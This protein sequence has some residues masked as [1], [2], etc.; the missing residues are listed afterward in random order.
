MEITS[1]KNRLLPAI[2][3]LI[4]MI[5]DGGD[6]TPA[7]V[8]LPPLSPD[9]TTPEQIGEISRQ[10]DGRQLAPTPPPPNGLPPLSP[11]V[12]GMNGAMMPNVS[13]Q[14]VAA[15]AADRLPPLAPSQTT[16]AEINA[17]NGKEYGK[18]QYDENGTLVKARGKDRA[19][20]WGIWGK[21][22][23]GIIGGARVYARTG[24]IG[25]AIVGGAQ[26]ASNRNYLAQLA[27]EERLNQLLPQL[28]QQ[29]QAEQ[30]NLG[31]ETRR[32]GNQNIL[33][34]NKRQADIGNRR[35]DISENS[36][37]F[38]KAQA[39]LK[40]VSS[41]A[42]STLK[43]VLASK[44]YKPGENPTIDEQLAKNNIFLQEYDHRQSSRPGEEAITIE[45][46]G[47]PLTTT[48]SKA[49]FMLSN[50]AGKNAGL[51][52]D[53][54]KFNANNQLEVDKQNVTNQLT[55][56]TQV[57]T[58]LSTI[59][60]NDANLTQYGGN[61][62]GIRASMDAQSIE[63]QQLL[64]QID[65]AGAE[66][67]GGTDAEAK[68]AN[69]RREK[70]QS[71]YNDLA[72][73]F[74]KSNIQLYEELGKTDAGKQKAEQL[75]KLMPKTPPKLTFRPITAAKVSGGIGGKYSGQSFR[76]SDVRGAF[77]GKTDA[78]IKQII[79]NN[80]GTLAN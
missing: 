31:Q 14:A 32:I 15:P 3:S 25:A 56:Q 34:D 2:G 19:K 76:L 39:K 43:G 68:A 45:I 51:E 38:R 44:Y 28:N 72:D 36:L 54:N 48:M 52:Q 66:G 41:E 12:A 62:A 35:A 69:A 50:I 60:A 33:E 64:Q 71:R 4:Q 29:Q 55:H 24:N 21:V 9:T 79:E 16:Q 7:P 57:N 59:L 53:T 11:D 75:R 30:F 5:A 10:Y 77:S 17:V 1:R 13:P 26:S 74:N 73:G 67:I 20:K 46:N 61:V 78:E 80:G 47:T 70:L 23:S 42:N 40:Q 58:V 65:L 6:E 37:E 63:A 22:K 49:G 18:A 27:D 8:R